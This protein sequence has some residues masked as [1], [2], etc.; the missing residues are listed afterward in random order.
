MPQDQ[1]T[2]QPEQQAQPRPEKA[3]RDR[4]LSQRQHYEM[5]LSQQR[6]A[7]EQAEAALRE[8]EEQLRVQTLRCQAQQAQEARNL[9]ASL[10]DA[11]QLSDEQTFGQSLNAI[12]LA[13]RQSL[14]RGVRERLRGGAP[15]MPVA[16]QN[17]EKKPRMS[18]QQAAS[19]Y[20]KARTGGER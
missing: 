7:R 14:E 19:L 20:A 9:P 2:P 5:L 4:L 16:Q 3:L 18:Y 1:Q 13:F 12:E 15:S 8:R 6:A 11:L 10:V 17:S